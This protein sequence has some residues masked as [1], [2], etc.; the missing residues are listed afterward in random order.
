MVSDQ[1]RS[2]IDH[3]RVFPDELASLFSDTAYNWCDLIGLNL[4]ESIALNKR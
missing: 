2:P 4:E 1:E 3:S